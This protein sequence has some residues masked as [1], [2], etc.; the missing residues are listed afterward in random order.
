MY[1]IK[2]IDQPPKINT[3][4]KPIHSLIMVIQK[5]HE[6]TRYNALK[7]DQVLIHFYWRGS[8]AVIS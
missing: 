3:I 1:R 7:P 5:L 8:H 4:K 2:T 6:L